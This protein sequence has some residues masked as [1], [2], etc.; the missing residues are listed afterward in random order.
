[1]RICQTDKMYR[2]GVWGWLVS[3][4]KGQLEGLDGNISGSRPRES[5]LCFFQQGQVHPKVVAVV[6]PKQ[7][8]Y[9]VGGPPLKGGP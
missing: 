7:R 1:M 8:F 4:A 9:E 2:N 3:K 6:F 5:G